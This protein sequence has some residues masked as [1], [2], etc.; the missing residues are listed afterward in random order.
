MVSLVPGHI[1]QM[2][3]FQMKQCYKYATVFV[4]Q[5]S[6]MGFVYLQKT[7]SA[8][9]TIEA[10]KAF[11]KYAA[12]QGVTVEAYHTDNGIFKANKWIKECQ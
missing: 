6:R 12:I 3:G 5:A 4:N 2:V 9:E 1:A 10:K 7:C 11:E 8:E